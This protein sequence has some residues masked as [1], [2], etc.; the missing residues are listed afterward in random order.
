MVT[1][2]G[3]LNAN[4]LICLTNFVKQ[5][6]LHRR[7]YNIII[8]IKRKDLV[9]NTRSAVLLEG[10]KSDLCNVEQ[11]MAQ[12]CSLIPMLFSVFIKI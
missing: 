1:S 3:K 4:V 11:G 9:Y 5:H 12:G 7:C 6:Y 2:G 8:I 10:E